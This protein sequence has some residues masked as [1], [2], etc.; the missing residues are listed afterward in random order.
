MPTA[1][2]LLEEPEDAAVAWSLTAS[3][4]HFPTPSRKPS[5]IIHAPVGEKKIKFIYFK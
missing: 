3:P 2:T 1:T 4:T 5:V